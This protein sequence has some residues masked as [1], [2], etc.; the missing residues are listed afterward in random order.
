MENQ[1]DNYK[2]SIGTFMSWIGD[3]LDEEM[4]SIKRCEREF[5]TETVYR[6]D[7]EQRPRNLTDDEKIKLVK[8]IDSL[9]YLNNLSKAEACRRVGV[10]FSTYYKWRKLL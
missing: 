2:R 1:N 9:R 7:H 4:A 5:G 6:E 8:D 3:K 10:H